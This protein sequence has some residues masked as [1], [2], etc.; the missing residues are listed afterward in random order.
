MVLNNELTTMVVSSARTT[1]LRVHRMTLVFDDGTG[2][3]Y[4]N[5]NGREF[6]YC[7][8]RVGIPLKVYNR[9]GTSSSY[10][11]GIAFSSSISLLV[12]LFEER[13]II[14]LALLFLLRWE[15][16]GPF[17]IYLFPSSCRL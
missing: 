12:H 2:G 6:E 9:T 7:P 14:S 16:F 5:D 3:W 11:L 15:L 8:D 17:I 13:S 10:H 1:R 4:G